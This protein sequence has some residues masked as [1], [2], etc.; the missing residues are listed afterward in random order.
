MSRAEKTETKRGHKLKKAEPFFGFDFNS[1]RFCSLIIYAYVDISVNVF[2]RTTKS[3]DYFLLGHHRA[4]STYIQRIVGI[5]AFHYLGMSNVF[6]ISPFRLFISLH[7][8]E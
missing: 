7:S 2:H 3:V 4:T 1:R 5:G 6:R 8:N